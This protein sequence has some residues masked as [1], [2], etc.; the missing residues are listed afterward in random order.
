M[1]LEN[2][3][4]AWF[5]AFHIVW[6]K[7]MWR[8]V[9]QSLWYG[10]L[11]FASLRSLQLVFSSGSRMTAVLCSVQNI[12]CSFLSSWINTRRV[13]FSSCFITCTSTTAKHLSKVYDIWCSWIVLLFFAQIIL[14]CWWFYSFFRLSIQE[15]V[16]ISFFAAW[17]SDIVNKNR[18]H[19]LCSEAFAESSTSV[20]M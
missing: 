1:R 12:F 16:L 11:V 3:T 9:L 15:H 8:C 17:I 18:Q 6:S 19:W 14:M 2:T 7:W 13:F 10:E 20:S 5:A 4:F